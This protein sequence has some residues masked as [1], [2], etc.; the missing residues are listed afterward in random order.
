[1]IAVLGKTSQAQDYLT[2]ARWAALQNPQMSNMIKHRLHQILGLFA[3]AK[4][5]YDEAR[6]QFADDVRYIILHF[7]FIESRFT[8]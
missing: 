5:D 8:V 4:S 6:R 3:A 1:M 7:I 2:Q